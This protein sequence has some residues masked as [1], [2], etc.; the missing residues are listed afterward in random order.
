MVKFEFEDKEYCLGSWKDIKLSVYVQYIEKLLPKRP[1]AIVKVFQAEEME[2]VRLNW[3][4]QEEVSAAEYMCEVVAYF[5]DIDVTVIKTI[6]ERET[7][8]AAYWGIEFTL[9]RFPESVDYVG[10][11]VEGVE[12]LLPSKFM[13]NSTFQ[14]FAECAQYQQALEKVEGGDWLA[15]PDLIAV[16]ARPKGEAFDSTKIEERR[17][18]FLKHLTMN[19][20]LQVAFFLHRLKQKYTDNLTIYSMLK[21]L[22]NLQVKE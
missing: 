18:L 21:A 17:E 12:Y 3:S 8:E 20:A 14:E 9:L 4:V 15:L 6:M 10:F 5:F 7:L 1:E 2:Q 22:E 13:E 11:K 16:L 19:D